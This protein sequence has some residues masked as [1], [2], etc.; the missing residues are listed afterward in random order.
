[1][2]GMDSISSMVQGGRGKEQGDVWEVQRQ[3]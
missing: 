2:K 3:G 1:M